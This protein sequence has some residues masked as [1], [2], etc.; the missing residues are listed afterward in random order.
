MHSHAEKFTPNSSTPSAPL[1]PTRSRSLGRWFQKVV[2]H[3]S[4]KVGQACD[5]AE[6]SDSTFHCATGHWY[7]AI[8]RKAR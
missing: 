3:R 1:S 6:L 7:S 4:G 2:A 5:L 8:N